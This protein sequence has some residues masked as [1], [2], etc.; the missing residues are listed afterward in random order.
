MNKRFVIRNFLILISPFLLM[1]LVNETMRTETAKDP[2]CVYGVPAMNPG[3]R[4][5]DKCSW[6]CHH[7]TAYC[8]EHHIKYLGPYLDYTDIPYFGMI[9]GLKSTGDYALAN[10]IV[11]VVICP[12][13]IW[14]LLIQSLGIQ[15]KINKIKQHE[16][17]V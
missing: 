10:I 15:D 8:K 14:F 13:L 5:P 11:Y 4:N 1:I 6:A 16:P 12:L 2:F 9:G 3:E 7:K 17:S